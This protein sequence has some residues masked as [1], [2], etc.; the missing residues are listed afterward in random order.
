EAALKTSHEIRYRQLFAL[1]VS[2][3]GAPKAAMDYLEPVYREH[4][5]DAETAGI[6][7]GIY[8]EIFKK[9]QSTPFAIRSRDTYL[10]NFSVTRSYYTGI[11]AATMSVLAGQSSKGKELAREIIALLKPS[12]NDFWERVTLAEAHLLC[13]ERQKAVDL[14]L[15]ARKMA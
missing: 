8:K 6:L 4:P 11:N 14:Y 3:S 10:K 15:D 13:Q 2:K 12:S 1:A 9:D 5:E 7:G